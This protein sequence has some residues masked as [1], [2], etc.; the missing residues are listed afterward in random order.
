MLTLPPRPV[1]TS[2][3]DAIDVACARIA[4]AWPLD[5]LIA[6]NPWWGYV[7]QPI[8]DAAAELGA[9]S[10]ARLTMPRAW[11]RAQ[12]EAGRFT[13]AH[14][15]RAFELVADAQDTPL[16]ITLADVRA[17]LR[18]SE[19]AAAP[20][21]ALMPEVVD[22]TRDVVRHSSWREFV[23]EHI[24][25]ACGAWFGEGQA[26]WPASREAGLYGLWRAMSEQDAGV[27]LLMGLRGFRETV[28]TLPQDAEAT[29]AL[30]FDELGVPPSQQTAY[31]TALLMSVSGWAAACAFQ[32]WEAR[33]A[34]GDDAQLVHLLAVRAAWELV[35]YRASGAAGLTGAWANARRAWSGATE[36]VRHRQ[37]VDWVL[38]RALELAWQLPVAASL[39]GVRSRPATAAVQAVFCID[40]RS[41]VMR[42]ALET[43]W[44]DV[45]TLGF[46]GFFGVPIAY[47]AADGVTRPQL[48][49]LLAPALIATDTG[50]DA[51]AQR[52]ARV[53][54]ATLSDVWK[55]F[56]TTAASAFTAV[57]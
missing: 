12:Y 24:S 28:E 16:T 18:S 43:A 4:P 39:Q 40:V 50:P 48:P 30:V 44:P 38:Q 20:V 6:V 5:R 36:V 35:L 57:E 21:M 41:E 47:E 53:A 9:V 17:A 14:L 31:A 23:V 33:L 32:R 22:A 49:G 37:A 19:D 13:D 56:T 54:D 1:P 55:R 42:R 25:H 10:G 51:E 3:R 34:G 45:Q 29:I 26:T 11:F 52:A 2:V 8:A 15:A 46:A 27:R 7:A